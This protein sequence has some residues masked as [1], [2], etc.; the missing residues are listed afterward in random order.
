[1]AKKDPQQ[2]AALASRII[3]DTYRVLMTRGLKG[4]FVYSPDAETRA[5]L[6]AQSGL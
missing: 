3:R 2:A 1:M 5:W 6:R 4:C